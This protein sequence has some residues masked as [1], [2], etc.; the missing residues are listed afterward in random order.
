[1]LDSIYHITLKLLKNHIFGVKMSKFCH[2]L[3]N[4]KMKVITYVMLL[5][6]TLFVVY[7]FYCIALYHFQTRHHVINR[8]N[9]VI[10]NFLYQHSL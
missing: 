5:I 4:V 7:R 10:E 9:T 8:D 3:C 2:L 1:M 6:C